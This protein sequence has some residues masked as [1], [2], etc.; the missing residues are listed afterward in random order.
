MDGVLFKKAKVVLHSGEESDWKIE[1]DS[2]SRADWDTLA[3]LVSRKLQFSAVVGIPTGGLPFA[4]ACRQYA[5]P[6]K[7]LPVLIVDDVLTTG[8]SMEEFKARVKHPIIGCVA[9]AR[10]RCPSW[11]QPI[12][13]LWQNEAIE[14][15]TGAG[16][17]R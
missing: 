15:E 6:F 5:D 1:C 8:A 2:F 9:F 10:G 4:E 17:G 16:S 12:F 13:Q 7:D 11:I 14:A 3:M